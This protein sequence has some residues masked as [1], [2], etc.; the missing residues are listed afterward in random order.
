MEYYQDEGIGRM[1]EGLKDIRSRAMVLHILTRRDKFHSYQMQ[2]KRRVVSY[3]ELNLD[4]EHEQA[5]HKDSGIFIEGV[6]GPGLSRQA[7]VFI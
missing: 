6:C 4:L 7:R 5:D 1:R 3:L 2:C